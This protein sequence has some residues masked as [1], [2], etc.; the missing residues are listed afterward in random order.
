[1]SKYVYKSFN[2]R[3]LRDQF[4][5]YCPDYMDRIHAEC[6]SRALNLYDTVIC[7]YI[8]AYHDNLLKDDWEAEI[9]INDLLSRTNDAN[10][11]L[12]C[13]QK[14]ETRLANL[15][16]K[17]VLNLEEANLLAM[18]TFFKCVDCWSQTDPFRLTLT[19]I[20]AKYFTSSGIHAIT[21]E[22]TVTFKVNV[23]KFKVLKMI[24]ASCQAGGQNLQE[25]E[26][27]VALLVAYV[28]SMVIEE[29]EEL[30]KNVIL[31]II[32]YY[33]RAHKVFDSDVFDVVAKLSEH[34]TLLRDFRGCQIQKLVKEVIKRDDK[35]TGLSCDYVLRFID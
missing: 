22:L 25:S 18:D 6:P 14:T 17:M 32:E 8:P 34:K 5:K 11:I 20:C 26:L 1:M 19:P 4:R 24:D 21:K 27:A 29:S 9:Q 10:L 16:Y 35:G 3:L 23:S 30:H 15:L 33:N 31:R 28:N 12:I 7:D 2:L 13:R